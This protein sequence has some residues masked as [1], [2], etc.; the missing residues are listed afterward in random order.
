MTQPSRTP[1]RPNLGRYGTFGLGRQE[2]PGTAVVPE[3]FLRWNGGTT[4]T[5]TV[6]VKDD[7]YANASI[8]AMAGRAQGRKMD[9]K[10]VQFEVEHKGLVILLELLLGAP[11]V[12]GIITPTGLNYDNNMPLRPATIEANVPGA[13]SRVVD[14]QFNKLS[15]TMQNRANF[16]GQAD[17][18]AVSSVDMTDPAPAVLPTADV[19]QFKDHF[20]EWNGG[21]A[22]PE[23]SSL[24]LEAGIAAID[25]ARGDQASAADFILGFERNG[26][27][28]LGG[29]FSVAGV[30]KPMLD[31]YRSQESFPL[32]WVLRKYGPLPKEGGAQP[33]VRE[34]RFTIPNAQL[35]M[36]EPP[37][38]LDRIVTPVTWKAVS[39]GGEAPFTVKIT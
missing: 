37:M 26:L 21:S 15:L 12:G 38:G 31:A 1:V 20:I 5:A 34:V 30:P 6:D 36:M 2:A 16:T 9:G 22:N 25:A 17:Y 35:S 28:T 19:Y 24:N 10:N 32:S 11:A 39:L 27:L 18:L 13:A 33:V 23:S 8:F 29:Q 4:P 14:A 7:N 3:H